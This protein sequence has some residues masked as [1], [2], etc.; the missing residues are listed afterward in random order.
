MW[1]VVADLPPKG[2]P[3]PFL[4][5]VQQTSIKAVLI[6]WIFRRIRVSF[7]PQKEKPPSF[8]VV[9][10]RFNLA[11]N[12]FVEVGRTGLEPVTP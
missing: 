7:L 11:T 10:T 12:Y 6:G 9:F 1:L 2:I 4:S 3:L 5:L 8:W